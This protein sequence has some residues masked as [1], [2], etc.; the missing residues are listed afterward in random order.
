MAPYTSPPASFDVAQLKRIFD[1]DNFDK[2]DAFR[3]L[4]DEPLFVPRHNVSLSYE[5]E[6]ALDRLKRVSE[7]KMISVFDFEK[8]PLNIMAGERQLASVLP[9]GLICVQRMS[10]PECSIR[11]LRPR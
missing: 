3:A 2:R 4:A 7:T 1:H 11:R 5:R 9:K 10:W 8:N 6:L